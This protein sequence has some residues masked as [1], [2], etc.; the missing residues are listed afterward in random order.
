MNFFGY[1]QPDI[2]CDVSILCL[3]LKDAKINELQTGNKLINKIK[4]NQYAFNH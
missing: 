3:K 4:Y 2:S 1:T